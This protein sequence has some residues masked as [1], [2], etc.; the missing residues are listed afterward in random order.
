MN[1]K[2][3]NLCLGC[4]ENSADELGCKKC[5]YIQGSPY[6]PQ[7]LAPGTLLSD[8]YIVGKLDKKDGEGATYIGLDTITGKKVWV[9]EYMPDTL[10][11]REVK[12]Q[13]VSA[14]PG[15]E[16][17][18]KAF[19]SDFIDIAKKL[20]RNRNLSGVLKVLDIFEQKNTAYVIYEYTVGITL[21][22]FISKNAGELTWEQAEVLFLPLLDTIST[23]HEAG[24]IHRGI[25]PDTIFIDTSGDLKL[26]DFLVSPAR[27]AKS[28]FVPTIYSGYAAPEQYNLASW[29]GTWTD[30]YG[31]ASVMYKALSGT[32]PPQSIT[33]VNNDNLIPLYKLNSK[34]PKNVSY[35]ISAA[36]VLS[37]DKRTETIGIFTKMLSQKI[38]FQE[39]KTSQ[40]QNSIKAKTQ[41]VKK[42]IVKKYSNWP[43]F[44]GSTIISSVVLIML[45]NSILQEFADTSMFNPE[46]SNS[47]SVIDVFE[48]SSS[49]EVQNK[50]GKLPNFVGE[51]LD[52]IKSSADFGV[53]YVIT[54]I[55]DYSER[56]PQGVVYEQSVP[57]GTEYTSRL[58]VDLYISKGQR[59]LPDFTGEPLAD[60]K[61][62]L[63]DFELEYE[64][65]SIYKP[66]YPVG[67]VVRFERNLGNIILFVSVQD[68]LLAD[69]E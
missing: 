57:E 17:Q 29:Q 25:S 62:M 31:V 32:R 50:N 61:A 39:P 33:R 8:K 65:V 67:T 12:N 55:H 27:I 47:S 28:E 52:T 68:S 30:V 22:E 35:A 11:K 26:T 34:V 14:Q 10:T 63:D 54:E 15:F 51:Y 18:Y 23:L 3:N 64:T 24:I 36:M 7:Y 41:N 38:N 16:T 20:Y 2:Y 69:E 21:G 37:P 58:K 1:E 9:R 40:G 53:K 19:K 49:S 59:P 44:V 48:E 45:L 42:K 6:N 4:M 46:Y 43:F 5:G 60:V 66:E 56:Y 13:M